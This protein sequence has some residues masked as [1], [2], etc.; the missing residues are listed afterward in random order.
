MTP[1]AHTH[2]GGAIGFSPDS[3]TGVAPSVNLRPQYAFKMSMINVPCNS[4]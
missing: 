3:E 1:S 4:H 2:K